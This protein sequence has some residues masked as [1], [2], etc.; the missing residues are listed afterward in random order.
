MSLFYLFNLLNYL[1]Q[2]DTSQYWYELDCQ[3]TYG[4]FIELDASY[5]D[6]M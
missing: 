2:G 1:N 4:L 5:V 3:V 6:P